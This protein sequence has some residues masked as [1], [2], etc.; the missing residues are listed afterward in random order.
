MKDS[1]TFSFPSFI[2]GE[3]LTKL[4]KVN[5]KLAGMA[6][7]NQVQILAET[8]ETRSIL[9][10]DSRKKVLDTAKLM[11]VTARYKA[12]PEDYMDVV[13]SIVEVSLPVQTKINGYEL[14]GTI[15]ILGDVKTIFS[16]N[17]DVNLSEVDVKL[18]HHC[19]TRRKRKALHVFTEEATGNHVAIGSTCVHD[20]IGLDIDKILHTFF[21]FYKEE[22]L[23][24]SR[25]MREAWGFPI[26]E[27]ANACRVAYL[28]DSQY[29]KSSYND[30]YSRSGF[31]NNENGTKWR[32]DAIHNI[33]FGN[34]IRPEDIQDK[35]N[36]LEELTKAPKVGKL[37]TETYGDL[38]PKT[39]NFN[40][41][42]VETLFY[43]DDEGN[44]TLRDF[45]VGKARGMF[46]WC[47]FNALNKQV[48]VE[49][50]TKVE[51]NTKPSEHVG[52]VGDRVQVSGVVKFAKDYD[53]DWGTRRLLVVKGDNGAEVKTYTKH[54]IGVGSRVSLKGTISKLETYK[55]IKSTMVKRASFS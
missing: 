41:N 4:A 54:L 24:G 39:S 27:L 26:V 13:F 16:L 35:A 47:V 11:P 8:I 29:V 40:S 33:M 14:A 51:E 19:N 1:Y 52:K 42:I 12:G 36:L 44:K 31:S 10:P 3:F 6:N 50:Q 49:V 7:A 48:K 45:I 53:S 2:K 55:G 22:D 23:Y 9:K 20:Y 32:V 28:H 37:L 38:D 46:V 34:S 30:G 5:K 25:G 17:D 43:V 21:N 15:N 18:C